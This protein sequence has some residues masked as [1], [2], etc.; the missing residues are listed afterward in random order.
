MQLLGNKCFYFY[1]NFV[2]WRIKLNHL[3]HIMTVKLAVFILNGQGY[4]LEVHD[5]SAESGVS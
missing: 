5:H 2:L 4:Q 3:E 1:V